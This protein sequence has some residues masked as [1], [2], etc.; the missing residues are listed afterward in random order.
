MRFKGFVRRK[1]CHHFLWCEQPVLQKHPYK[2]D[3]QAKNNHQRRK[4]VS[5]ANAQFGR[6]VSPSKHA[7]HPSR[8]DGKMPARPVTHRTC[9]CE[10]FGLPR[11]WCSGAG[12]VIEYMEFR[13]VANRVLWSESQRFES[14][15]KSSTTLSAEPPTDREVSELRAPAEDY[16]ML[17][18]I[19]M[20][21][22]RYLDTARS[23]HATT[24]AQRRPVFH[25]VRQ[26]QAQFWRRA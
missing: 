1:I 3:A 12:E 5:A 6:R 26:G 23:I 17:W 15:V 16:P 11:R 14:H 7:A 18:R 13:A 20:R 10:A 4:D 8:P 9:I 25:G 24:S 2:R 19:R 21:I 22:T